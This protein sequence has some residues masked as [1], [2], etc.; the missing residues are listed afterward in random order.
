MVPKK[1]VEPLRAY[2]HRFLRPTCMP[3]HHFG[4]ILLTQPI[5]YSKI[6]EVKLFNS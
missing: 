5:L 4:I 2:A 1:G 6:T 3:F